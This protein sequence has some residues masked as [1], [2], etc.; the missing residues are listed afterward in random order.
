MDLGKTMVKMMMKAIGW[1]ILVIGKAAAPVDRIGEPRTAAAPIAGP[2]TAPTVAPGSSPVIGCLPSSK[3]DQPGG[4]SD[5]PWPM[6]QRA[7]RSSSRSALVMAQNFHRLLEDS[8]RRL[9]PQS[10]AL[11]SPRLPPGAASRSE[12]GFLSSA[13]S[14]P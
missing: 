3:Y 2:G 7:Q 14:C 13:R 8:P 4:S 10:Q 9:A 1:T 5:C 12:C 6:A 11:S